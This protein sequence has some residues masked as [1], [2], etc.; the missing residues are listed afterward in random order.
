M[1]REPGNRMI[2]IQSGDWGVVAAAV[3]R[4]QAVERGNLKPLK[5]KEMTS[6]MVAVKEELV[7]LQVEDSIFQK[8]KAAKGTK[9]RKAYRIA[10]EK[11]EEIWYRIRQRKDE[12]GDAH[13]QILVSKLLREKVMEM[14]HDSL[15]GGHLGRKKTEYRIQT[16]FFLPGLHDNVTS[17][18]DQVTSTRKLCPDDQY[19]G[20][21]REICH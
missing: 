7:R 20:L 4:A 21:L 1:F 2:R 19:H 16:N 15:F 10:N 18:A 3:A 11:R 12:M 9:T 13:E 5:V 17:F 6:K 14:A 8:F